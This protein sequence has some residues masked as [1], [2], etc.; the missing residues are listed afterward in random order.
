VQYRQ[1]QFRA[2]DDQMILTAL[3]VVS[4][5]DVASVGRHAAGRAGVSLATALAVLSDGARGGRSDRHGGA[6]RLGDGGRGLGRRRARAT[7]AARRAAVQRRAGNRVGRLRLR[8]GA[9]DVD[10][11]A[12]VRVGVAAGEGDEL[13]GGG[14]EAAAAGDRDLR[15]LG[16]HLRGERV[17]RDRLEADEVV[18]ARHGLGDGGGPGRVLGDHLA[19]APGAVVD[20]AG[21]QAGLVDL[22]PLE[23]GG[24]DAGARAAWAL[25]EVGELERG[26]CVSV[27]ERRARE[28]RG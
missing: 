2:S 4:V 26:P 13:V 18:A 11:E 6:R 21:Q 25:R 28:E 27:P 19:R 24:V 10:G 9:V 17:E 14:R 7:R 20:G 12:G 3:R 16:V 15:A 5:D 8:R 22:E 23:R 1:L